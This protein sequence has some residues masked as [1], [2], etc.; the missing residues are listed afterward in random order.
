M[1]TARDSMIFV[2]NRPDWGRIKPLKKPPKKRKIHLIINN[3]NLAINLS[4]AGHIISIKLFYFSLAYGIPILQF[5]LKEISV[6]KSNLLSMIDMET[7]SSKTKKKKRKWR[8]I[9]AIHDQ[10]RLQ[11]ELEEMDMLNEL[12]MLEARI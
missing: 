4:S 2:N 6:E 5:H 12:D 7:R 9:E 10:Y 3:L 1:I 8:E 11:R